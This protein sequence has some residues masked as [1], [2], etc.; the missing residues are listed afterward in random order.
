MHRTT[1]LLA[2]LA[3][4]FAGAAELPLAESFDDGA[5][6][7]RARGWIL[8]PT[9]SVV[10][11]PEGGRCLRVDVPDGQNRY[12]ERFLPVEA[13]KIYQ[14]EVRLR[15]ENVT[16][17]PEAGSNRGAVLFLQWADHDR[18]HVS[19]GAFPKG[20]HGT[21]DWTTHRVPFTNR[22][23]ANVGYLHIL[24]G[25]EGQG[26][27]WFDDLRVREIAPGWAGPAILKPEPGETVPSRRPDVAWEAMPGL[28]YR[29]E[30]CRDERFL[31]GSVVAGEVRGAGGRPAAWLE[32]GEW[33]VRV[34]PSFGP[35]NDLPAPASRPFA[36]AADAAA[37]PP[38]IEPRWAWSDAPRPELA[39]TFGPPG[40]VADL[41]AT[42]GGAPAEITSL[43]D[44]L[45]RF[46][47]TADLA[48]GVHPVRIEATAAGRPPVV[49]EGIFCNKQPGSRVTFRAGRIA[50]VDG[51]PFFPLGT[52][53]DPSD[54]TDTFDGVRAAG[55]NVTHDY[56]F[57]HT[58]QPPETARSYLDAAHQAGT[59]VFL[60]IA[61]KKIHERDVLWIQR[62]VAELMDHPAILTWYL[63]DEPGIRGL[64]AAE[65]R[66]VHEMVRM[67]DPFHPT[68]VVYCK[69]SIFSD[70]A[71]CQDL[72]WHDPYPLPNRPLTMVEDWV[73]KG[74]QA[75][76]EGRPAWTVLQGHDYR[77]WKDPK[78]AWEVHGAPSQPSPEH[79]R[80]MTFL[81]LAAGTD[82]LVWYWGPRSKYRMVEDAPEAWGGIVATVQLLRRIEPWLVAPVTEADAGVVPEP[83]RVWTRVHDGQ[84]LVA[85]VNAGTEA[86]T[87]DLDLAPWRAT[88]AAD[89]ETGAAIPLRAGRVALSLAP[90][91]V[92]LLR[93]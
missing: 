21:R 72:H 8:R 33:Q 91:Q 69:P 18:K 9:A 84:R 34:I 7:L 55:F 15:A 45:V 60:G 39:A 29:L 1:S 4:A 32:P 77:F 41:K 66:H 10:D 47:P 22:I 16:K 78:A 12:A 61:R 30:F 24:L 80:C 25:V 20:L 6:A 49:A 43:G 52:Y 36:V 14:A 35:G 85:V 75:V 62:W 71:D 3:A 56:L 51:K 90:G 58:P 50:L 68:S 88:A 81:A 87:L 5:D 37:W 92:R 31:P 28:A 59:K 2:L 82:G 70:W 27:A 19:G 17:H 53:R 54:R 93:L 86:A 48:P 23:P 89:H 57:E 67:V 64:S 13:G 44:G 26:T 73:R 40:V 11:G 63:M 83:F 38:D 46:R 79:T 74:R 42:V 65:M 76:G